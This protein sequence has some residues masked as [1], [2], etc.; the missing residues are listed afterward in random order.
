MIPVK[1]VFLINTLQLTSRQDAIL[2]LP[3]LMVGLSMGRLTS[4]L[5][6]PLLVELALV[7]QQLVFFAL[8]I[9]SKC[10]LVIILVIEQSLPDFTWIYQFPL[11]FGGLVILRAANANLDPEIV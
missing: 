5:A 9:T 4:N 2:L 6:T 10:N 7:Q 3:F 11:T 1:L 8:Q